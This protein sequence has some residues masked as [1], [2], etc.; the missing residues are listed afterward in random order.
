MQKFAAFA[1]ERDSVGRKGSSV[2]SSSISDSTE[3]EGYDV[4]SVGSTDTSNSTEIDNVLQSIGLISPVTKDSAGRLYHRQLARQIVEFLC[5]QNRLERMGGMVTLPDLYCLYNRAR[6]TELVSPDDLYVA[7]K[8]MGKLNLG[9]RMIKYPSGVNVVRL[10]SLDDES[11][12]QRLLS[13]FA[14]QIDAERSVITGRYLRTVWKWPLVFRRGT[15]DGVSLVVAK[16][17]VL[18]AESKGLLCRDETIGG[19]AFFANTIFV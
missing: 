1:E 6:G 19:V 7:S 12:I 9:M 8:L 13:H 15:L 4:S 18:M 16:E 3:E 5:C 11:L 2:S 14:T 10:D 17:Q